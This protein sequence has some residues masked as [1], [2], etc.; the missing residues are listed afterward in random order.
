[1]NSKSKTEKFCG[2]CDSHNSY[3]Y[4]VKVFCSTR[5]AESKNPIVETLGYC[6]KWNLVS[7][8]C[9]CVREAQK[10]K[11]EDAHQK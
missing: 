3:E 7:Q 5:Y 1:M 6:D 9:Y 4:P 11:K 2:N 8:D 10:A